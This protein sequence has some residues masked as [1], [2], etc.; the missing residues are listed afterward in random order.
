MRICIILPFFGQFSICLFHKNLVYS[1][2]IFTAHEVDCIR[3]KIMKIILMDSHF[4]NLLHSFSLNFLTTF[5]FLFPKVFKRFKSSFDL[6]KLFFEKDFIKLTNSIKCPYFRIFVNDFIAFTNSIKC[7]Y[8]MK[9][10]LAH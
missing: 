8:L 7:S 10:L 5:R 1:N 9:S 4:D 3:E 2:Y 6:C